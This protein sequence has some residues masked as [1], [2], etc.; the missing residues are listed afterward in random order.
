MDRSSKSVVFRRM[1][2]TSGYEPFRRTGSFMSNSRSSRASD[3]SSGAYSVDSDGIV[4]LSLN[5][6]QDDVVVDSDNEDSHTERVS[7]MCLVS[8]LC[9]HSGKYEQLIAARNRHPIPCVRDALELIR[10]YV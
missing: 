1:A 4:V 10:E 8:I 9:E 7:Y 2:S 5:D 3:T 6:G